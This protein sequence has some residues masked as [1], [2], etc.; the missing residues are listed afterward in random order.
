[1]NTVSFYHEDEIVLF[2]I[3]CKEYYEEATK[4]Y[5]SLAIKLLEQNRWNNNICFL[6]T[7]CY[8]FLFTV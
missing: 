8:H 3:A 7:Q 2:E 5:L 4:K 1:M 6:I